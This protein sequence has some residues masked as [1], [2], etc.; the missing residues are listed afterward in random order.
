ME[1]LAINGSG[2]NTADPTKETMRIVL[3]LDER[4]LL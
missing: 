2:A 1:N 4:M 3:S